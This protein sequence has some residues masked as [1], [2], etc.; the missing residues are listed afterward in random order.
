FVIV[1]TRGQMKAY[2][3]ASQ[4]SEDSLWINE[5]HLDDRGYEVVSRAFLNKIL[6]VKGE[7]RI[8]K[9]PR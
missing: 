4:I 2:S 8:P 1:D 6:E 3:D 9:F 5:I 7:P